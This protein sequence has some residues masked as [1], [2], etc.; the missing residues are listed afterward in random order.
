M[1]IV[2]ST[3]IKASI[4]L[5]GAYAPGET[6]PD[7]DIQDGLEALNMMLD[8]W[9][10]NRNMVYALTRESFTLT[11]GTGVYTMGSGGTL[12]T[13]RPLDIQSAYVRDE[14]G[15]DYP[16]DVRSDM[17]EYNAIV[18][19]T[20]QGL[21]YRL[22]YDTQNTLGKLYLQ[23]AP[24]KAYTLFVDSWK[25]ISQ[26]ASSSTTISLPP[27]YERAIKYNLAIELAPE[28]GISV[29]DEVAYIAKE[30][31]KDIENINAPKPV[32]GFEIPSRRSGVFNIT[33]GN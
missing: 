14:A 15:N 25:T 26:V 19:K 17:E 1:S 20:T 27:G 16:V 29:S 12:S 6:P 24:D 21:P 4:R 2:A 13:T 28:Y 18:S 22:W 3:L 7:E 9:G 30:S 10:L 33:S 8:S 31:K 23:Y 5:L 11:P 32:A